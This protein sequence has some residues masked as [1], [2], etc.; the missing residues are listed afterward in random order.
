[1]I[2]PQSLE[3]SMSRTNF[4]GP[5]D[6]RA[7][8]VRMYFAIRASAA[9]VPDMIYAYI[10]VINLFIQCLKYNTWLAPYENVSSAIC[11]QNYWLLQNFSMEGKGQASLCA[12][13]G[14]SAHFTHAQRH[15]LL[16]AAHVVVAVPANVFCN[17]RTGKTRDGKETEEGEK[18]KTSTNEEWR[19]QTAGGG[20][21]ISRVGTSTVETG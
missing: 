14:W 13:A 2:N 19:V 9:Y 12:C 20:S 17:N 1:M 15:V 21:K 7:I 11:G 5:N 6:V 16:D 18:R 4:Y 3:L 8:E 10:Q